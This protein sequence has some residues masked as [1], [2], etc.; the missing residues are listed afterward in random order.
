MDEAARFHRGSWWRGGLADGGGTQQSSM[1]VI[2][3]LGVGSPETS[4][5]Y[6]A[7][8]RQGLAETAYVEGQNVA[9]QYRWERGNF[10]QMPTL[11]AELVSRQVDVIATPTSGFAA[12]AA[13][14]TIPIVAMSGGDPVTSG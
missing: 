1:P 6:L 9:V 3:Y 7:P 8:F 13:T 14:A 2:G 10:D 4:I 12:K 5:R 11:A